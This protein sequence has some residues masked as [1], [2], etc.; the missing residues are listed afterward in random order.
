M[1]VGRCSTQLRL[2]PGTEYVV[3]VD[4]E[5]EEVIRIDRADASSTY[6]RAL[7]GGMSGAALLEELMSEAT[8]GVLYDCR[9]QVSINAV[10]SGPRVESELG[11]LCVRTNS[12]ILALIFER[13]SV[14]FET[15]LGFVLNEVWD[16]HFFPSAVRFRRVDSLLGQIADE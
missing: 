2:Q 14:V 11:E 16:G 1:Q 9:S 15:R 13:G 5:T 7:S 4:D 12:R 10:G 3:V 8:G 6:Q